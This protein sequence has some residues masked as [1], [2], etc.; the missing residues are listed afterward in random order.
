MPLAWY[1]MNQWLENFAYHTNI[2]WTI[3]SIAGL[4]AIFIAL[5]TISFHTIKAANQDLASV[6]KYE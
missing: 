3:F 6:L 1:M 2:S 4:S 5:A